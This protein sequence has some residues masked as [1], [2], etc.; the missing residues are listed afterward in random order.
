MPKTLFLLLLLITACQQNDSPSPPEF[1][2]Y[3]HNP[4]LDHGS[5]G[6][7]DDQFIIAPCIVLNDNVFYMFYLGCNRTGVTAVGLATSNDGFHFEKFAGNPVVSPDKNGF[8]AFGVG[9]VSVIKDDSVILLPIATR[10]L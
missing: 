3:Q 8:D 1:K 10:F 4:V 9:V 6:S 2:A 5:P 7:W